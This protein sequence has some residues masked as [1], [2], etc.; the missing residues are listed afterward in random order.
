[1]SNSSVDGSKPLT[2]VL[3]E[4]DSN[5]DTST[6]PSRDTPNKS[7]THFGVSY[8]GQRHEGENPYHLKGQN[9]LRVKVI[10]C[11]MLTHLCLDGGLVLHG[12]VQPCCEAESLLYGQVGQQAISLNDI[13]SMDFEALGS[14]WGSIQLYRP[15]QLPLVAAGNNIKQ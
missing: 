15:G 4:L 6:L 5:A 12:T 13:P 1:M 14:Q 10:E 3:Q 9:C 11:Q 8:V 2:W 7:S